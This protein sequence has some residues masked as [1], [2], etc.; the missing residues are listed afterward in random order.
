MRREDHTCVSERAIVCACVAK[1]WG[2]WAYGRG[3][4]KERAS[5]GRMGFGGEEGGNKEGARHS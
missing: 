3:R 5:E 1:S 2:A 4:M